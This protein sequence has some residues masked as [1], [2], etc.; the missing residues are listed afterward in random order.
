MAPPPG[1]GPTHSHHVARGRAEVAQRFYFAR[2]PRR[3]DTEVPAAA[4]IFVQ[5]NRSVAALTVL[6]EGPAPAVLEFDPPLEG[7][8]EWLNTSLYRFIP[9]NLQPSTTYPCASPPG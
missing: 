9:S 8:G 6:Q 3:G 4:Q 5:F 2:R 7:T 1:S